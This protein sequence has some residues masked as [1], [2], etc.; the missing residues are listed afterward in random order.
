MNLASAYTLE[1]CVALVTG[2]GGLLGSAITEALALCGATVY[3]NGRTAATLGKLCNELASR[4]CKVEPLVGDITRADDRTRMIEKIEAAAGKLD[5]LVNNA[6]APSSGTLA[7]VTEDNF[8]TAFASAV[9]APFALI[10]NARGLLALAAPTR[11]GGSAVVNVASMYASVSPD[12]R[13]YPSGEHA[14]P[15]QYGAAKAGLVQ[16]TRYAACELAPQGIR[17]NAV[18]PGPVLRDATKR[19]KPDLHRQLCAKLPM[20][21]TGEPTEVAW[22]VAFLASS[23][24]SFVTGANIPV[25]GG[26]TAW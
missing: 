17:V 10:K 1:G 2:A 5:I 14:N 22:V 6:Y 20:G 13:I 18:S 16:L 9:T 25:D 24:A 4:G 7:T 3:A 23:A 12:L 15:P 8:S 26:W 11:P 21:R 19:E